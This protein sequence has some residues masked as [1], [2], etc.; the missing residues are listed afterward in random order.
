MLSREGV[1]GKQ[2]GIKGKGRN[3][4]GQGKAD[5]SRDWKHSTPP[6]ETEILGGTVEDAHNMVL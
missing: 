4:G 1:E 6:E 5:C 2:K 3:R